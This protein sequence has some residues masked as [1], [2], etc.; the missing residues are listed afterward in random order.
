MSGSLHPNEIH[1]RRHLKRK[2]NKLRSKIAA[3]PPSQR[4][5]FEAKLQK[6]Y[7]LLPD[8]QPVKAHGGGDDAGAQVSTK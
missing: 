6:T 7:A 2:R 8:H 5:A 3:A 1:R 4:A